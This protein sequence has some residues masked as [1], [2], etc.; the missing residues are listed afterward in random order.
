LLVQVEPEAQARA[1]DP[2]V[3]DLAQAP[4]RPGL[5]QGVCDLSQ[6][7]RVTDSGEAV[8]LLR[9]VEPGRLGG[10]GE[11]FVAVEDDLRPERRMPAHLDRHVP[12]ARVHDVNE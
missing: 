7:F 9:E 3:D 6:A 10:A 11:I 1:V 4:Y 2:S 8:A 5:G 12:E